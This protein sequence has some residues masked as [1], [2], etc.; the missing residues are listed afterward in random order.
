MGNSD[1][2]EI[3]ERLKIEDVV[4]EYVKLKKAGSSYTGLCP[5]HSEKSPSF[6]VSPDRGIYKCFGCGESGDIFS[7]VEKFEN[8]DFKDVLKKL[9]DKSGV[10]LQDFKKK[11]PEIE[12][13]RFEQKKQ[14]ERLFGVL[15]EATKFFQINLLQ[16]EGAKDY[17]KKR[18]VDESMAKKFRL[19]FAKD[20]WNSLEDFLLSK[21]FTKSEI[22]SAGLTKKNEKGKVYDRFRNRII[23]PIFDQKDF[24]VA[25]S[26]RDFSNSDKVAKYLNSPQ[27]ELFD[28]SNILFGF[29]F[30]KI[31]ARKRKYFIL[32]E[33]Q[34][35]LVMSHKIGFENTVA[36]S[37]T[38][39][40]E[41][42]LKKLQGFSKNLIFAFDS[43]K[44]GIEA[45]FKGIKKALAL[46]FDVKIL[47]IEEGSDPADI[48]LEDQKK[49][50]EVVKDSKNIVDFYIKKI[51]IS[52]KNLKEKI[53]EMEEKI[54]PFVAEIK[55]PIEKGKYISKISTGFSI[56][57]RFVL[58]ALEI[59][60][61][62]K[63]IEDEKNQ[64]SLYSLDKKVD[65]FSEHNIIEKSIN[66]TLKFLSS[67]YF[68]QK[69]LNKQKEIIDPKNILEIIEKYS[70][71]NVFEKIIKLEENNFS[72]VQNLIFETEKIYSESDS[73]K[74]NF[75]VEACAVVLQKQFLKKEI[76]KAKK[77]NDNKRVADLNIEIQSLKN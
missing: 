49:W 53:S 47:D 29:N 16:N 54:L 55:N 17:L 45:S 21:N 46:D 65:I 20:E 22:E 63:K 26:G 71:K 35:D 25:Y 62:K 4:S 24:V 36:T 23:F 50:M 6:N 34:M 8:M 73:H 13:K 12:R 14:K 41:N 52:D 39:L 18:G 32:V 38:S 51:L 66:T 68:W 27:T 61:E 64:K 15:E 5:F 7:F 67:I 48:I 57:Q 1:V 40:T 60:L 72:Y 77:E 3:K 31:E 76:E 43:D 44:A 74:I 42:Q 28:K 70:E 58:D 69:N 75:D 2:E 37:G 11:S 9:A 10:V 30:A 19:G 59:S 33:G 56:D